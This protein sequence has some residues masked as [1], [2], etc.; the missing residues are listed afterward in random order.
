MKIV[1]LDRDS[2][3]MDLDLSAFSKLG[4]FE[5]H[6]VAVAEECKAWIRDADIVIFKLF[7]AFNIVLVDL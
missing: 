3:G 6:P 5:E 4:D 2:L 1:M 7:A